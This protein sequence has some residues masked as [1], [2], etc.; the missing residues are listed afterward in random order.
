MTEAPPT[1]CPFCH[2]DGERIAFTDADANVI[3]LWDAFPV[4]PG[5]LLVIPT[6]HFPTW[7]DATPQEHAALVAGI[8]QARQTIEAT[9]RPEGYN[10]GVNVGAAGGQTVPH[11][12]V[13]VIPRYT[14]DVPNARGGIR[15][16]I[17]GP[18]PR[19]ITGGDDPLLP[20]LIE[21]LGTAHHADIAVGFSLSGVA[22]SSLWPASARAMRAPPR[23]PAPSHRS[24]GC[25]C[26]PPR[27]DAAPTPPI[28]SSGRPRAPSGS[29]STRPVHA[30]ISPAS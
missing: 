13:H 10:I 20:Y 30:R 15:H 4:T 16:V 17:P 2:P 23:R 3:G 21:Q 29:Q 19:L 5:H 8:A 26:G 25:G 7:F 9:R 11:L 24:Q 1:V 22:A 12:H 6:R 18:A 27:S 28:A 14:G